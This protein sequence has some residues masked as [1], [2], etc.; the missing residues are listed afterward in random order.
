MLKLHFFIHSSASSN[1]VD[2]HKPD[3]RPLLFASSSTKNSIGVCTFL[4]E[5]PML[6]KVVQ[7]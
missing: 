2:I 1:F 7:K 4:V 3:S 6:K 5:V